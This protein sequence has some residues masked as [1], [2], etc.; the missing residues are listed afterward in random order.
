LEDGHWV[1]QVNTNDGPSLDHIAQFYNLWEMLQS[2]H[3]PTIPIQ[4]LGSSQ[5]MDATRLGPLTKCNFW[6]K[7]VLQ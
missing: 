5:M 6:D 2:M 7:Q 1:T 3:M 4:L